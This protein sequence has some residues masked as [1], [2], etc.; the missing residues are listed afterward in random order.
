[1]ISL[2]KQLKCCTVTND[3]TPSFRDWVA[4]IQIHLPNVKQCFN[5]RQIQGI[6]L[7]IRRQWVPVH[8]VY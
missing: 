5:I 7:H 4:N 8:Y 1:M 2:K 3:F 6:Y